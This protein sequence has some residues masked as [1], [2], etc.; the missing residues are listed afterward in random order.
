[1][2]KVVVVVARK[3]EVVVGRMV[4]VEVLG[5]LE[6]LAVLVGHSFLGLLL[7][8]YLLVVPGILVVQG[9]VEVEVVVVAHMVVVVA[10]MASR[11][12]RNQEVEPRIHIFSLHG[13]CGI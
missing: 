8:P 1:M 9:L 2:G 7:V 13:G 11:R 3:G 6:V 12:L 4:G 5:V 10:D